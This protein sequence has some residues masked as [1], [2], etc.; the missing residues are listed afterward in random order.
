MTLTCTLAMVTSSTILSVSHCHA[1]VYSMYQ[2]PRVY[3]N[4]L[5]FN[6][7]RE[8]NHWDQFYIQAQLYFKIFIL[9]VSF[10]NYV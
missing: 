4:E 3:L 1:H 9:K 7:N 5:T 8:L 2:D 6:D 10:M